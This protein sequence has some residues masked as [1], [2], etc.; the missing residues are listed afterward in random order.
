[1]YL[2]S[3]L[4][5]EVWLTLLGLL[6]AT[7]VALVVIDLVTYQTTPKTGH[8]LS[9]LEIHSEAAFKAIAVYSMQCK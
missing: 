1:M 7:I 2:F 8:R 5:T 3:P 9:W 6:L 4:S